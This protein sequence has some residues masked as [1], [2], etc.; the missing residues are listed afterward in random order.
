MPT[1]AAPTHVW[2]QPPLP[3]GNAHA[4]SGERARPH[5]SSSEVDPLCRTPSVASSPLRNDRVLRSPRLCP[6]GVTTHVGAAD[7]GIEVYS[8]AKADMLSRARQ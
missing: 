5:A 6:S 4:R 3:R 1:G 8:E 2:F 7:S